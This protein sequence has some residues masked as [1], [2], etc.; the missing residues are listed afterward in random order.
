M[1]QQL[2]VIPDA[3]PMKLPVLHAGSVE[4]HR[5]YLPAMAILIL[6]AQMKSLWAT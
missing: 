4:P 2:Q 1:R 6:E 3:N 5:L